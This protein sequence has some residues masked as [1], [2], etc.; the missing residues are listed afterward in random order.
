M[1]LPELSYAQYWLVFNVLSLTIAVMGASGIFF[2]AVRNYVAP[3]Y[4]IALYLSA[5]VVFIACYHYF[6]IF[7]SWKEAYTLTQAGTYVPSGKPFNDFY[8]YADWIVTVPLLLME[9]IY[10]MALPRAKTNSLIARLVIA[11]IIMLALGYP[12]EVERE[13]MT[14]RG[15]WFVLACIPFVYI[16]YVL[17]AE[18]NRVIAEAKFPP[19]VNQLL[20]TTRALLIISW[21]FY[22]LAYLAP[23]AG[24]SGAVA[25]VVLQVGYSVADLTAK[26]LFG[27]LLYIIAREKTLAEEPEFARTAVIS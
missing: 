12:G 1:G 18:L 3:K 15:T 16:L 11:S 10:V 2:L 17:T 23:M 27:V 7:E 5:L 14:V 6:R 21:M 20:A 25:E 13:N 9:L 4:H 19:R 24:F 22:P 8:R 26:P